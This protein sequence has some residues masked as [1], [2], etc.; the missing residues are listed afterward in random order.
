MLKKLLQ[1]ID[2]SFSTLVQDENKRIT[3]Q[4]LFTYSILFVVSSFMTIVNI[5]TG[6]KT[7]MIATL[8]FALLC[9]LNTALVKCGKKGIAISTVLF[10]IEFIILLTFFIVSGNP[11]GFSAIWAAMLPTCGMILFQRKKGTILSLSMLAIM[12][13]FFWTPIGRSFLN[14]EYTQSFMLRFPMLY[15]AFFLLALFLETIRKKTADNYHYQSIHDPLTKV[16]NRRGFKEMVERT[17][18]SKKLTNVGFM[19]FDIDHFKRINDK[20]GHFAGDQ[21]L[22]QCANR[23]QHI[24]GLE[25]CRWG[26]EEFALFDG[27]GVVDQEYVT[28]LCKQI[29]MSSFVLNTERIPLTMSIGAVRISLDRTDLIKA[30]ALADACLYEAKESGRNK[31]VFEDFS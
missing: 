13:F 29:E 22:I 21:F 9:A 11:E 26:G 5:A 6:K 16:Y 18:E 4:F 30:G 17:I 31:A 15:L 25:L 10:Q 2:S 27:E 14:Y 7:L 3:T 24:T 20:Y 23:I 19:I 1:K 12:I 8:V 28:N